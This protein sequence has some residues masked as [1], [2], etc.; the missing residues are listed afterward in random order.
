MLGEPT[1]NNPTTVLHF[2]EISCGSVGT[3][4]KKGRNLRMCRIV[5]VIFTLVLAAKPFSTFAQQSKVILKE[6]NQR[7]AVQIIERKKPAII[8]RIRGDVLKAYVQNGKLVLLFSA[9][10][11][12]NTAIKHLTSE[13]FDVTVYLKGKEKTVKGQD[14]SVQFRSKENPLVSVLLRDISGS[15]D[16]HSIAQV[17]AGIGAYINRLR[18][19]DVAQIIDFGSRVSTLHPFTSDHDSLK[20]SLRIPRKSGST[21]FYDG[22]WYAVQQL[23][24]DFYKHSLKVLVA[25]TDGQDTSSRHSLKQVLDAAETASIP[26]FC[27]GTGSADEKTLTHIAQETHGLYFYV[28]NVEELTQIY[29]KIMENLNASYRITVPSDAQSGD[30]ISIKI[31]VSDEQDGKPLTSQFVVGPLRLH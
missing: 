23:G 22:L 5:V 13:N 10:D 29:D 21:S 9:R 17:N 14:V 7:D 24:G 20:N 2:R 27:I 4:N 3:I 18:P 1:S 8:K 15:I 16:D 25:Y 19:G 6:T 26:I 28:R 31:T 12:R 30:E 11:E